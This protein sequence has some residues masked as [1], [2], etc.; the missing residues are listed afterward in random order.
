M[1]AASQ[2]SY[3]NVS[4]LRLVMARRPTPLVRTSPGVWPAAG[5]RPRTPAPSSVARDHDLRHRSPPCL[6][7]SQ[8]FASDPLFKNKMLFS[9]DHGGLVAAF[10][11][12]LADSFRKL[13]DP[14]ASLRDVFE[15][16]AAH[17]GNRLEELQRSML[18]TARV[19]P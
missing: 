9:G 19:G 2:R 17:P 4:K 11:T 3:A 12:E 16:T 7:Q 14:F 5:C 1:G 13:V 10:G 6:S 15:H 18:A 8:R